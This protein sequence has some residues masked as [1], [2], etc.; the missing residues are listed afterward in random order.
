MA[1]RDMAFDP[2]ADQITYEPSAVLGAESLFPV[3]I[4]ASWPEISNL[5]CA[6]LAIPHGVPHSPGATMEYPCD[7]EGISG[8]T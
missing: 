6:L 4:T 2:G 8:I 5:I 1:L 3:N 7:P